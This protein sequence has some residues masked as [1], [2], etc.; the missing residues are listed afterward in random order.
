MNRSKITFALA[1]VATALCV[2]AAQAASINLSLQYAGSYASDFSPKG[3]ELGALPAP[4]V[5]P[6][7]GNLASDI[8]EFNVFMTISGLAAGEDVETVVFDALL[9]PGV[10]PLS[11]ANGGSYQTTSLGGLDAAYKY[12]PPP[13]TTQGCASGCQLVFANNQDAGSNTNDLKAITMVA[14]STSSSDFTAF[15]GVHYRHPGETEAGGS[16][17]DNGNLAGPLYIGSLWVNWDGTK[18]GTGKSFIGLSDPAN[19]SSVM[20][21]RTATG[22]TQGAYT[23]GDMTQGPNLQWG[24]IPEPASLSLLGIAMVGVLGFIRRR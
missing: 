4:L 13:N 2:A 19:V 23:P 5:G 1:L 8:H 9:G 21:T 17:V 24:V 16:D 11:A 3:L 18:D 6:P 10:T 22:N 15:A 14:N 12:D 20:T 7:T